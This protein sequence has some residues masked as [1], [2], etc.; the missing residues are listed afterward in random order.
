MAEKP[1]IWALIDLIGEFGREVHYMLDDCEESGEVGNST[2]TV[3]P[4]SVE[5]VSA[6][7]R[8]LWGAV[9]E[10]EESSGSRNVGNDVTRRRLWLS[11]QA[12]M[13]CAGFFSMIRLL[14]FSP[15]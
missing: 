9:R 10:G 8:V 3:T 4:E 7:Q 1:S 13:S 5:K 12:M 2:F 15:G 14:A 11:R 6:C